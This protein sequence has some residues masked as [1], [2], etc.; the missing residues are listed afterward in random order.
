[1]KNWKKPAVITLTAN[2][3][4]MYIKAAARSGM[5]QSGDFR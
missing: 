2:Q 5:C 1:M 3:L 4:S